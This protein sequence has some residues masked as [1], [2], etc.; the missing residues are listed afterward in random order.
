M[1]AEEATNNTGELTA[2]IEGM[3]WLQTEMPDGGG[4]PITIRYDSE[5]AA[6]MTRGSLAPTTNVK[7]VEKAREVRKKLE[8]KRQ[9]SWSWV[10]GHSGE[11]GNWWADKLADEG[12]AGSIG[13]NNR[14]WAAP[15][16]ANGEEWMRERCRKCGKDF[17][18]DTRMCSLHERKCAGT[19]VAGS[20]YPGYTKCR[21]CKRRIGNG[22]ESNTALLIARRNHEKD[23]MWTNLANRT[24]RICGKIEAPGVEADA[25]RR[26]HEVK[27]REEAQ[28]RWSRRATREAREAGEEDERVTGEVGGASSSGP[29]QEGS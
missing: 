29:G 17:E 10:K 2:M 5:Y 9:I 14:R 12:K 27:C 16:P 20:G 21:K 6:G 7:L 25:N 4:V 28:G 13:Q 23:C 8:E 15:P 3:M 18:L 26:R 22:V 19:G 24:C 11:N 1:G